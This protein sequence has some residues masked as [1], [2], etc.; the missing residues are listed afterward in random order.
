MVSPLTLSLKVV[1]P[2]FKG[3][4]TGPISNSSYLQMPP[5]YASPKNS[6]VDGSMMILLVRRGRRA[7][8]QCS[9]VEYEASAHPP[10][11]LNVRMSHP[12]TRA[13]LSRRKVQYKCAQSE[14]QNNTHMSIRR[15]VRPNTPQRPRDRLPQRPQTDCIAVQ[16]LHVQS[17]FVGG[18]T[19]ELQSKRAHA[20]ILNELRTNRT[21]TKGSTMNSRC[22]QSALYS[23][24]EVMQ[25]SL[26]CVVT[27]QRPP[28][29][30]KIIGNRQESC[31][32]G[33]LLLKLPPS[34]VRETLSCLDLEMSDHESE[35]LG[36]ASIVLAIDI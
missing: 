12:L 22:S 31:T 11:A 28:E 30:C 27:H 23:H 1:V 20:A 19:C 18:C 34:S 4:R 8:A 35:R 13:R 2:G 10:V 6:I 33:G 29:A 21:R 36:T 3:E 9:L 5:M 32:K 14:G 25:W 16:R 7:A 15:P 24:V 26:H 17:T